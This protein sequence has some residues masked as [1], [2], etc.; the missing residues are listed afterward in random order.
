MRHKAA[1]VSPPPSAILLMIAVAGCLI[2]APVIADV[3]LTTDGS[4]II[5]HIERIYQGKARIST[6]FAGTLEIDVTKLAAVGTDAPVT[7]QMTS[8]DRLVGIIEIRSDGEPSVIHASIGDIPIEMRQI[9]ALW[10]ANGEDPEAVAIKEKFEAQK[11]LLRPKWSA[12]LEAGGVMKEGNADTIDGR[13]R[14]DVKRKTPDDLLEFFLAAEYSEQDDV[15]TRNEYRGGVR[16]ENKINKRKYW[17]T[18]ILLEFDEFENLDLRSTASYGYGYYWIQEDAHEF[19]TSLGVGY[20]HESFNT[21]D[22]LDSAVIDLGLNYRV[23]IGAWAQFTHSAMYAPD[24]EDFKD[25]RLDFD[26]ALVLPFRDEKWKLK[27][28]I[29][30]EYNALPQRGIERL[31]NTYYANIVLDLK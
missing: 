29:R 15:R 9:S 20:R 4:R 31:D 6:E 7:V 12:T 11:E 1:K 27:L 13:G 19:K 21:G 23:D 18:R 14:F 10:A 22:T 26:T 3:L 8:G 28:G 24:F 5:G 25:F 30:N 16:F 2:T 17:Y